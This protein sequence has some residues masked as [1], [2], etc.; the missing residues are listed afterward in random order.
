MSR[1]FHFVLPALGSLLICSAT[2]AQ[3]RG[4]SASVRSIP[5]R[6]LL[7]TRTITLA[8][9]PANSRIQPASGTQA[10]QHV[11]VA[12]FAPD[13]QRTTFNPQLACVVNLDSGIAVPG[14]GFD[15]PHL[16]AISGSFPFNPP[17]E[18]GEN[19]LNHH[20]FAPIFFTED[21]NFQGV[22]GLGFDYPHLAAISGNFPFNPPFEHD[23]IGINNNSFAP[24]FF[25]ENPGFSDFIDP[26]VIQQVQQQFQQQGQQQPQ[27]IVIQ[28][29]APVTVAQPTSPPPQASANS[30]VPSTTPPSTSLVPAA[31]VRDVGEF[32]LIR[33]DG[34]VLFASVFY[35]SGGQLHYVTPEGIRHTVSVA[36]LDS[37]ATHQMNDALG[38]AVQ[39]HN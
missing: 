18:R 25:S 32:I 10:N 11:T 12:Q 6:P 38:S 31:A 20:F 13:G 37:N 16:A 29:P 21:P 35:V 22:P 34:R 1:I 27:I 2:S 15:Y 23:E 30:A 3:M 33:R 5:A 19:G 4:G 39:I 7:P 14:L 24:I 26:A 8:R 9:P 28:Q 17:I 36:E